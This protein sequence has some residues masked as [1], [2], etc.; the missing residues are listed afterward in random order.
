MEG[1]LGILGLIPSSV[2]LQSSHW[3]LV[4]FLVNQD[5][6]FNFCK[7]SFPLMCHDCEH[8]LVNLCTEYSCPS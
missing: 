5:I 2:T 1:E 6:E 8:N 4:S 3:A 7:V